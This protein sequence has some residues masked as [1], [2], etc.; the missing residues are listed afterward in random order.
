YG[1]L[2]VDPEGDHTELKNLDNVTVVD[3]RQHLPEPAELSDML[4]PQ[5]SVVVDLSGLDPQA[6]RGYVHRL[7]PV[8]EAYREQYG[9]PHWVI[10][11]EAHLLGNQEEARWLR[12]G[13]Y[14]LSSFAPATLPAG[15]VDA[16]DIVVETLA[17]DRNEDILQAI[18]RATI[19]C[20]N[21]SPRPFSIAQ[22]R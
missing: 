21:G 18:P 12:R 13:G 2:V 11:D 20:G 17:L 15:E 7:R 8:V 10:Y 5:T 1:V 4:H 19:R 22:R 16:S 6:K 9:F 14:V 3:S